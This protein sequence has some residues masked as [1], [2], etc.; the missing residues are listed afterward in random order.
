MDLDPNLTESHGN[1]TQPQWDTGPF[2]L[3]KTHDGY[4]GSNVH[5][6]LK[7]NVIKIKNTDAVHDHKPSE[8][9]CQLSVDEKGIFSQYEQQQ[10]GDETYQSWMRKIGPYLADWVLHLPRHR[11]FSAFF[12][13]ASLCSQHGLCY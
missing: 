5:F 9:Q 13:P 4:E 7:Y 6:G 2:K 11:A 12:C 3:K 10:N 8:E 1:V